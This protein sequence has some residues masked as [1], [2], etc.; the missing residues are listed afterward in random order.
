MKVSKPEIS[1]RRLQKLFE[2]MIDIYSPSGKEEEIL[3]YLYGYL[4]RHRLTVE[5]QHFDDNRHNLIVARNPENID[6]AL[7]GHIDTVV[8][9]DF[10]KYGYE[11]E[12]GTI[13][14]LGSAD[15]K[16]GCAA[17]IEA[18]L[19]I[20]EKT[21][22]EIPVALALVVGEEEDG[23]GAEALV[24]EYDFPWALI[25]EPTNLVP[26]LDCYGYLETNIVA[27]G[28]RMHASMAKPGANPIEAILRLISGIFQHIETNRPEIVF[29]IR[30][31][32]SSQAGFFVPDHCE[33]WL[34]FHFPPTYP[35]GEIMAEMEEILD[36]REKNF[37][38]IEVAVKF[39][40][41]DAGYV[42]P[43]K[44][45]LVETIQKV[46]ADRSIEWVSDSFRSHSDANRLWEAGV[47]PI[48]LGPGQLEMAH[49]PEECIRFDEVQKAA[50]IYRDI[51]FSFPH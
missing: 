36:T 28:K 3:D 46:F 15:M 1:T 8:A 12:N 34:D 25:G 2:K 27:K 10:E 20:M 6:L 37:S 24:K 38:N 50:E 5:K 30:D 48:L 26:C 40:T 33:S 18:F 19:S 43:E 4:K 47:R 44:G 23:D 16:G 13:Y 7:L 29:N 31:M 51:I 11:E 39:N 32:F 17:M 14:G 22:E 9:Y 41:V 45:P 49:S 42:L 35:I 21:D